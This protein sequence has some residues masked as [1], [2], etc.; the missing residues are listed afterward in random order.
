MREVLVLYHSNSGNTK[1]MAAYVYQGVV[2]NP[3][4]NGKLKS[5]E[6]AVAADIMKADGI[7]LGSPTNMG[8]LS[9]QMKKFWDEIGDEL[10]GK[11]DG[12]IGCAFSSSGGWGGG[13]ELTCQSL[14]TVLINYGFLVFG[15]TDYVA[16]K[17]TLHY[18]A[19]TAGEPREQKEIDAC[20]R[21][22]EKLS[23]WVVKK[24]V[25]SD[26]RFY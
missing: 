12:K 18:G 24:T 23:D 5:I 15:V 9:W 10:W 22:G 25:S 16:D 1:K 8:I 19:V 14:L 4:V 17:F 11:V 26:I 21:L 7:A 3:E 6:E 13:N 2:K 20:I